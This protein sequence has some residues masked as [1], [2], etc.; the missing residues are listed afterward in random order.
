MGAAASVEPATATL[1]VVPSSVHSGAVSAAGAEV[2]QELD[3]E[4]VSV[5]AFC[6][7]DWLADEESLSVPHAAR[8]RT[9]E[10]AQAA[11][12]TRE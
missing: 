4:A 3:G 11:S 5:E 1:P 8:G 9:R 6:T 10:A 2:G 12:A 7:E